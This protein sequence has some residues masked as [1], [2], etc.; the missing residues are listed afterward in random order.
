[1]LTLVIVYL[2]ALQDAPK[3]P[4][5]RDRANRFVRGEAVSTF[6]ERHLG[7]QGFPACINASTIFIV[8]ENVAFSSLVPP[9]CKMRSYNFED[10]PSEQSAIQLQ[11]SICI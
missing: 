1:M 8:A 5:V 6:G 2:R 11:A 9:Y 3:N 7:P 4:V 10:Y